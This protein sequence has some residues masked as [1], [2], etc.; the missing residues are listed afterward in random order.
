[1]IDSKIA[2]RLKSAR[3]AAGHNS[4]VEMTSNYEWNINTYRS[5]ENGI[6]GVPAPKAELY[7]R[8]FGVS[9]DWLLTGKGKKDGNSR[10]IPLKLLPVKGKVLGGAFLEDNKCQKGIYMPV[11][12][13]PEYS[14]REQYLLEVSGTSMNECYP[15]GVYV[16]CVSMKYHPDGV[17]PQHGDHVIVERRKGEL[18][19]TT[20]K[21]YVLTRRGAELWPRSNDPAW[22]SPTHLPSDKP[23]ENMEITALVIGLYSRRRR[24]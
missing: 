22:Q 2:Q 18:K 7:A 15:E 12:A 17:M 3:I 23:V 5:H 9:I 24:T 4:V 8:A 6:R 10:L 13:D 19:E 16:H 11:A 20:I 21:E 14:E 1:M